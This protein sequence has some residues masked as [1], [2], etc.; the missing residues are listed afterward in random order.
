[1][2]E[3]NGNGIWKWIIATFLIPIVLTAVAW[4]V[5]NTKIENLEEND[6]KQDMRIFRSEDEISD[7][8][9]RMAVVDDNIK[10]IKESLADIKQA[11]TNRK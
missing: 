1:M 11:L 6:D 3:S 4:G 7:Q 8:R 2:A 9:E 10:D 5:S